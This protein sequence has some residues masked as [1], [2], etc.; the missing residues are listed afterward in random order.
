MN[1]DDC[2]TDALVRWEAVLEVGIYTTARRSLSQE[3][4]AMLGQSFVSKAGLLGFK[5]R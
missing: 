1:W 5:V 2:K 4:G 3:I